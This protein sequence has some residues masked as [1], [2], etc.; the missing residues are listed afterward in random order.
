MSVSRRVSRTGLP[1]RISRARLH[2]LL[3]D[4]LHEIGLVREGTNDH[5]GNSILDV[6]A[7]KVMN[8]TFD[9][10]ELFALRKRAHFFNQILSAA[11]HANTIAYPPVA[12]DAHPFPAEA[13]DW[14][15]WR[16]WVRTQIAA[17]KWLE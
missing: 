7:G 4:L 6:F 17:R 14:N 10:T 13:M 2:G 16:T 11:T 3:G 1:Q 15:N 5:R 9:E 12:D 8:H